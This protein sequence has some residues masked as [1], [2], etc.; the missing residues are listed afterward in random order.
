MAD[1]PACREF[2]SAKEA[3]EWGRKHYGEWA[4]AHKRTLFDNAIGFGASRFSPIELYC[5]NE[6]VHINKVLRDGRSGWC[7]AGEDERHKATAK[8]IASLILSAPRMPENIVVYRGVSAESFNELFNAYR[9]GNVRPCQ[10]KGF[11]STSLISDIN[12]D[13]VYNVLLRI[14]VPKHAAGIYASLIAER[15]EYEMLML[16]NNYLRIIDK[17]QNSAAARTWEEINGYPVHDCELLGI[18]KL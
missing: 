10:E 16:P 4:A 12:M 9:E 6:Y 11:M 1:A 13:H 3:D 17:E 7:S 5:G 15:S 14:R 8:E 18:K 2:S